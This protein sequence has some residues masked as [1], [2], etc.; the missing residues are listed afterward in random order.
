[1]HGPL[2][3]KMLVDIYK[4]MWYHIP[5][6]FRV[7]DVGTSNI[8]AWSSIDDLPPSSARAVSLIQTSTLI[9]MDASFPYTFR[10]NIYKQFWEKK[11]KI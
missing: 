5:E 8:S 2:N 1:M 7:T 3:K 9:M 4:A 11:H 10:M 6:D